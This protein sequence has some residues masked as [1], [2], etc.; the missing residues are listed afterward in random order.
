MK[1]I[2]SCSF[3][4]D[5]LAAIIARME[6]GEPVDRALY[7]RIMF[8]DDT[9]AEL[10][11]HE[12]FIYSKG[13]PFLEREY[14]IK[15]DIVQS[16]KTYCDCFYRQRVNGKRCGGIYGFPYL[17]GPWCNSWLKIEPLKDYK[18]QQ[19]KHVDIVGI[20]ADEPKRAIRATVKGKILPLVDYGI[21]ET[22]AFDICRRAGVLSQAYDNQR[23]RL[24][25][26]FCHNQRVAELRRLRKEYPQLWGKLMR[27]DADSP[28][29]FRP[30]E[31][32]HDIDDRFAWEDRQLKFW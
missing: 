3:G 15:T 19:G 24:G 4:K 11:E 28:F 27:L 22:M 5:S 32:L 6:H 1:Y 13:I 26:W 7:V 23:R 17:L 8:D 10:P 30:D 14:G 2:A 12:E 25:C 20:A 9:S 21:T 16:E 31:T 18:K 29:K